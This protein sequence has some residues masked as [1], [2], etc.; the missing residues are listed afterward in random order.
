MAA[1]RFFSRVT[2]TIFAMPIDRVFHH[3]IG[4]IAAFPTELIS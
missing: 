3:T 1:V 4:C 2:S